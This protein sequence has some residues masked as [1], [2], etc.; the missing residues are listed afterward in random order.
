MKAKVIRGVGFRGALNYVFAEKDEGKEVEYIGGSLSGMNARNC[1]A[2]FAVSRQL[3]PD[4]EKPVWHCPLSAPEG[5]VLTAEKW[6]EVA[7]D[8]LKKMGFDLDKTQYVIVRH[9]D[10]DLDHAHIVA[11]RIQLDGTVWHGKWEARRAIQA[12]QEIEREHGLTLTPGIESQSEKRSL[13]ANEINRAVRT[14]EEPPRQKL[15]RLV[16][17]ALKD[18]PTAPEFAERLA[19]A[20]IEVRANIASTGRM[21]GF[22]FE[23]DGVAMKGSDL[24]KGYKWNALIEKGLDYEQAR[25]SQELAQYSNARRGHPE[26]ENAAPRLAATAGERSAGSESSLDAGHRAGEPVTPVDRG[27]RPGNESPERDAG[28]PVITGHRESGGAVQGQDGSPRE[29]GELVL[30]NAQD[31]STGFEH[32]RSRSEAAVR[33][34]ERVAGRDH[35]LERQT[36]QSSGDSRREPAIAKTDQAASMESRS[37]L[38]DPRRADAASRPETGE[39]TSHRAGDKPAFSERFRRA[40]AEKRRVGSS[41]PATEQRG[42]E[43]H[44]QYAERHTIDDART[45]DPSGFLTAAGY[46]VKNEGR[47]LSV[48]V[49]KDEYYRI[50]QQADG[51]YVS[52]DKYGNGI[53]DN[54]ALYQEITGERSFTSAVFALAGG[55]T[56]A[57]KALPKAPEFKPPTIPTQTVLQQSQ[58]QA[59]GRGYLRDRGISTETVKFAEE[60]GFLSHLS[61][62]CLFIGRDP[63]G[64][65]R[66]VT[67]RATDPRAEV[68]KRDFAGSSKDFPPILPGGKEVWIVEGGVDALA[69]RDLFVRDNEEAPTIIVSGGSGC[70]NFLDQPHIQKLVKEA[71]K[72]VVV[73]ENEK[74]AET[75]AK[76]DRAHKLQSDAIKSIRGESKGFVWQPPEGSKDIAEYQKSFAEAREARSR[77]AYYAQQRS[78]SH[79]ISR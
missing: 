77:A 70:R 46:T 76:T 16:D 39:L 21:N 73:H 20:G 52:C 27:I 24:G 50:T 54:I 61:D 4:I 72:V 60:K 53:G 41:L 57:P 5:E 74:D 62:G 26:H 33:E 66:N 48:R 14:G 37:S 69:T 71:D 15:Q 28:S 58:N 2:E 40:A 36:D 18:K 17:E 34:I 12:T 29:V 55:P 64:Q 35:D 25:D 3:R 68:Q 6:K 8:Y 51:H 75:Q 9:K 49:E 47:H 1:S 43:S 44:G 38:S 30:G 65:V 78:H 31:V 63:S 10:T 45:L 11:S 13:T 67:K 79:G 32:S 59:I 56:I 23:V 19:L 42:P 7:D 22:S